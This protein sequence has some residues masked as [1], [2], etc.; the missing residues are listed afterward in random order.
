MR[1]S[2]KRGAPNANTLA[3]ASLAPFGAA[4]AIPIPLAQLDSPA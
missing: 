3:A 4:S 1:K 2:L